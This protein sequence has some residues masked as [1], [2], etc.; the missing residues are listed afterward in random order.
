MDTISKDETITVFLQ[1]ET[2]ALREIGTGMRRIRFLRHNVK[3]KRVLVEDR[4]TGRRHWVPVKVWQGVLDASR[5]RQARDANYSVTRAAN[6][7]KRR[8]A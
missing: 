3:K 1:D 8:V 6:S 2:R 5:T 4:G 7:R